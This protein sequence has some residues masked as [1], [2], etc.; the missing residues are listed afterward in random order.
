M[1]YVSRITFCL[2]IIISLLACAP[3]SV[4]ILKES[5]H[6]T[7]FYTDKP[8]EEVYEDLVFKQKGCWVQSMFAMI[9]YVQ[10]RLNRDKGYGEIVLRSTNMG[11][12]SVWIYTL[13]EQ[14]ES[15]SRTKT[16]VT[17]YVTKTG[18]WGEQG[19]LIKNW[20]LND[21]DNCY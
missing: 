3:N 5:V 15:E 14:T 12:V 13:V 17:V 9:M 8:F 1:I 16:K 21:T 10:N 6:P 20:V 11:D 18:N 7:T 2:V 19:E 4:K